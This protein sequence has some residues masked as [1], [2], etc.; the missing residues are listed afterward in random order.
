RVHVATPEFFE[1]LA[2][3]ALLGRA[4]TSEDA[5]AT[6]GTPPAVLSYGFWRRR[7]NGASAAVGQTLVLRGHPFVI[8]GV[9]PR[10]FNGTSV[11][12]APD[13]RVPFRTLQ[14]L[15]PEPDF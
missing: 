4:L 9:M 15:W 10:G 5:K 1:V 6:A 12:T 2:V 8:V 3:P 7:F 11:D 14:A 13:V